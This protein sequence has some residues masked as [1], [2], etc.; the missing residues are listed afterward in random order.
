MLN[1][2]VLI[3][4]YRS[5]PNHVV[6][7]VDELWFDFHNNISDKLGVVIIG[8]P[9]K[10]M[11]AV[12][13]TI[14]HMDAFYNSFR[15]LNS[16]LIWVNLFNRIRTIAMTYYLFI[17]DVKFLDLEFR[18]S[19]TK[20]TLTTNNNNEVLTFMNLEPNFTRDELLKSYRKLALKYHPDKNGNVEMFRKLT[21][22][23]D[24][25]EKTAK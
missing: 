9:A 12:N 8:N 22:Y 4:H 7:I 25:L 13:S 21:H 19:K 5:N 23:K 18:Y 11:K 3:N 1:V 17:I 20:V 15:D 24:M 2:N 16:N 14:K 10:F 6:Y